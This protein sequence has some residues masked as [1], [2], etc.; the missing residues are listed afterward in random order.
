V[1]ER[2][3]IVAEAAA[4]N[5]EI[6]PHGSMGEKLAD[7]R[8]AIRRGFGKEKDSGGKTIDAM[9]DECLSSLRFQFGGKKRLGG[10]GVGALDGHGSE[11]RRLV[12]GH[13]GIVLVKH[14]KAA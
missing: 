13:D 14:H 4:N 6:L 11:S 3:L 10:R 12:D 7:E 8:F 9:H 5:G 1:D 2:P